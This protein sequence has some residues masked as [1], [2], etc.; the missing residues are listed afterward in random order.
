MKT[1]TRLLRE[2]GDNFSVPHFVQDIIPITRIWEDGIFLVGKNKYSKCFSFSDVNYAVA[3]RE[4]KEDIF[5]KY[6]ELLNSFDAGITAKITILNR[7]LNKTDFSNRVLLKYQNDNLDI[8]RKEYNDMLLEKSSETNGMIQEKYITIS[9]FKKN[10]EEARN[11]FSR[12]GIEIANHLNQ[13]GSRCIELKA[14]DRIRLLHDFYRTG[15][16]NYF[17]FDIRQNMRLGHSFKD[18]VCPDCSEF[19][20]DY[21]KIGNR[22]GRVLFLKEYANYIKDNMITELTELNQNLI[23]SIDVVPVPTDEAIKEVENRRLGVETNIT[24]WQRRQNANNNYSA[25]IPYDLEQQRQESKE[26]LDDLTTRDQK[27]FFSV[28]TMVHTAN[29]KEELDNDTESILTTIRKNRCQFGILKF[30]QLE[31]LNTSLPIGVRKIDTMR[32]LTT[33]SLSVLIPF[34]AQEI[35]H[36]KGIYYGINAISKNLLVADRKLL[37]NGNSFILGVSGSGKSFLAKLEIFDFNTNS[38]MTNNYTIIN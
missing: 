2:D 30:Q 9:I 23:M 8:Y 12:V 27:M 14:I 17:D 22:Y 5:L 19:E 20:S 15:E 13:I 34:K 38:W 10:I 28:L 1:F 24:N 11:Y 31:G 21:F 26:F 6:S 33:E 32:T 25:I 29:T 4:D 18:Y 3:S 7:R 35:N 36:E 16:E 37:L